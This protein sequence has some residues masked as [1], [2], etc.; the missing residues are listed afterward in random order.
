MDTG[1]DCTCDTPRSLSCSTEPTGGERNGRG[2]GVDKE[3]I[4]KERDCKNKS[5]QEEGRD[6]K[7]S[8]HRK[9]KRSHWKG[10]EGRGK[11]RG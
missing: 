10:K 6:E 1:V 11:G 4:G 7:I 8:N 3:K 9:D 2:M 5:L